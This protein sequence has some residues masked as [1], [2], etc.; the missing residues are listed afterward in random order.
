M[1]LVDSFDFKATLPTHLAVTV[2]IIISPLSHTYSFIYTSFPCIPHCNYCQLLL[3]LHAVLRA[4]H[5]LNISDF[6]IFYHTSSLHTLIIDSTLTQKETSD[7]F[8]ISIERLYPPHSAGIH[9]MR[10]R[11]PEMIQ[12]CALNP[13][14]DSISHFNPTSFGINISYFNPTFG[15]N[16][17]F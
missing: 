2:V 17:Q 12:C 15:I 6:C 10:W 1:S 9:Q 7:K 13:E 4:L 11:R 14:G 5:A 16:R 3:L 8:V